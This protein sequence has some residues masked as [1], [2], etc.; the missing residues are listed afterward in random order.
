MYSISIS[1]NADAVLQKQINALSPANL[2][3]ALAAAGRAVGVAAEGSISPYPPPSGKPLP[4]YYTRV[5]KVTGQTY[6]SKFKS[7]K[8][9]RFVLSL[10]ARGLIPY[11]RTGLLGRSITSDIRDLS[12]TGVSAVI[13]TNTTYAPYVIDRV[14][15]SHYH[16]G[17]WTPLQDDIERNLPAIT[18]AGNEAFVQAVRQLM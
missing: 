13:G 8:Q 2:Q 10:A 3:S 14:K 6:L 15:Q 9:Q 17:N 18:E 11:R 16:K 5:S 1:G 4:K 7:L 12:A